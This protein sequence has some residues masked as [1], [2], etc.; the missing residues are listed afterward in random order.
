MASPFSDQVNSVD[1]FIDSSTPTTNYGT[2]VFM[3][4]G[5]VNAA[6]EITRSLIKWDLSSIPPSATITSATLSIYIQGNL[7]ANANDRSVYAYRVL[8]AWTEAGATWNKYDGTND[9]GTAGCSNTTS[10]REA[11]DIGSAAVAKSLPNG[12]E[13]QISLTPSKVQEWISGALTNNGIL[14]KDD[15]EV[16]EEY[17]YHTHEGATANLRPKLVINYIVPGGVLTAFEI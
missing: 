4:V 14:L 6:T 7:G 12:T 9:W 3:G 11:T 2:G 13:I 17:N 16:D 5:E 1:T 8:R 15:V 10:D